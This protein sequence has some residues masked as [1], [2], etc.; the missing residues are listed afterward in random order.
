MLFPETMRTPRNVYNRL[1]RLSRRVDA[2]DVTGCR[3][4]SD[5]VLDA[6]VQWRRVAECLG[7]VS[8]QCSDRTS[9]GCV[10]T[11]SIVQEVGRETEAIEG[12]LGSLAR[13]CERP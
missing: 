4:R 10:A 1:R 2:T 9:A 12:C 11:V 5:V 3:Y 13:D 8:V 6:S 7:P